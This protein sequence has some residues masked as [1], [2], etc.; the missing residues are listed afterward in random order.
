ML[1]RPEVPALSDTRLISIAKILH[2]AELQ[3]G[4]SNTDK[5]PYHKA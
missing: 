2:P 5:D 1:P 4:K 3:T